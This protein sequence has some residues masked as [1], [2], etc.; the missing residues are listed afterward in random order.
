MGG[1]NQ[2]SS[3]AVEA[4]PTETFSC[5]FEARN[6]RRVCDGRALASGAIVSNQSN[7]IVLW[8][9]KMQGRKSSTL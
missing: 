5:C 1:A 9:E 8:M 2:E 4:F 6:L 7:E 3:S